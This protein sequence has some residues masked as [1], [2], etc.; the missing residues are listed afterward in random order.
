MDRPSLMVKL[1][2]KHLIV[3]CGKSV[4]LLENDSVVQSVPIYSPKNME[5]LISLGRI[6]TAKN[7]LFRMEEFHK[8][9]IEQ[10]KQDNLLL[11]KYFGKKSFDLEF[12]MP[13]LKALVDEN[14]TFSGNLERNQSFQE[15]SD[16]LETKPEILEELKLSFDTSS[17][18][19][20]DEARV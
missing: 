2:L 8:S 20:E 17:D 12:P 10:K 6:G 5:R 4:L 3:I 11:S 13:S 16:T 9:K 7:I 15:I 18:E 19:S 1:D 14:D